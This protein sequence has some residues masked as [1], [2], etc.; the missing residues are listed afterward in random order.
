MVSD[1]YLYVSSSAE[2]FIAAVYVDMILFLG[3]EPDKSKCSQGELKLDENH[4][5]GIKIAQ[6]KAS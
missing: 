4:F 5:L 3:E 1:P 2:M 6:K